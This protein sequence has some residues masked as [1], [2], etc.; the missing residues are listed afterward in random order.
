MASEQRTQV[1][2]RRPRLN[3]TQQEAG[4]H[5]HS[6]PVDVWELA[7]PAAR[8]LH[9]PV[10]DAK[11]ARRGLQAALPAALQFASGHLAA[12]GRLLIHCSDGALWL[13]KVLSVV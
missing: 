3:R 4:G 10:Q 8:Y 11:H 1:A 13:P 12:G 6:D 7:G 5:P 2:L 9:L